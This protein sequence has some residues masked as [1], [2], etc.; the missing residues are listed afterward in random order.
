MNMC[1]HLLRFFVEPHGLGSSSKRRASN[2][3][4]DERG[5][6]RL[7]GGMGAVSS[8][9]SKWLATLNLLDTAVAGTSFEMLQFVAG[10]LNE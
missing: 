4:L 9:V 5:L 10:L 2:D 1:I 7:G 8:H 6:R 3:L